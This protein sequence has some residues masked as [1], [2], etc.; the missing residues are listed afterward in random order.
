MIFVFT[1]YGDFHLFMQTQVSLWCYILLPEELLKYP[2]WYESTGMKFLQHLLSENFSFLLDFWSIFF[3]L[4]GYRI[5]G[6]QIF[7][8]DT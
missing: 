6:Y 5:L 4:A 7:L 2:P 3:F 8:T 1:I